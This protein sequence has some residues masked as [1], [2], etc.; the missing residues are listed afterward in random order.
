MEKKR[1]RFEVTFESSL[2]ET[3]RRAAARLHEIMNS[4][5]T[6]PAI[7][8]KKCD[9]CSL[10]PVC[11]PNATTGRRSAKRFLARELDKLLSESQD[12]V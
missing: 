7:R 2:R 10:L 4:G 11:L 12:T 3:T 1:R 5:V 9:T 8:E 6:P